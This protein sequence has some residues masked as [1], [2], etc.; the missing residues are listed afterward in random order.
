MQIDVAVQWLPILVSPGVHLK[1]PG[2][3]AIL[4]IRTRVSTFMHFFSSMPRIDARK[5]T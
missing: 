2:I 3:I 5:A 1:G 4:I